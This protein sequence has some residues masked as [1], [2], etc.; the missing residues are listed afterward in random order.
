MTDPPK[1][2]ILTGLDI[3]NL[4]KARP[5]RIPSARSTSKIHKYKQKIRWRRLAIDAAIL[6]V[7]ISITYAY[8]CLGGFVFND[9]YI[10]KLITIRAA[11][12]SFWSNLVMKAISQPL[13]QPWI[14]AGFAF[15]LQNF[16]L[17]TVWYHIVN[18][19]LHFLSCFYFYILSYRLAK[20]FWSTGADEAP[21]HAVPLLAAALFACHPLACESVAHITG[22]PATVTACNFLLALNFFLSGFW[23]TKTFS[24]LRNYVFSFIF[25]ILA[26]FSDCQ[27]LAIPAVMLL[28]ALLL[29]DT[30][31]SYTNWLKIKWADFVFVAFF[32]I[33]AALSPV[34]GFTADL[35]NGFALPLPTRLVYIASQFRALITYYWRCFFVPLGLSVY[36]PFVTANGALD[37]F[38]ILG[39]IVI[40]AGFYYIYKWRKEPLAAFGLSLGVISFLPAI[41]FIQNE[42]AADRRFYL[43]IAG[44]SL[45]FAAKLKFWLTPQQKDHRIRLCALLVIIAFSGITAARTWDFQSDIDLLLAARRVNEKDAWAAGMLALSLVNTHK[46]KEGIINAKE[47]IKMNQTCQPAY[48]ALG[49][50]QMPIKSEE[51]GAI[52]KYKLAKDDFE[53]ALSLARSQHL[54]T[55]QLFDSQVSLASALIELNEYTQAKALAAESLLVAPN[56]IRLDLIMGRSLNGLGQYPEAL[57]YLD[58]AYSRDSTN[59]DLIEPL[60][61]ANLGVGAAS[62]ISTAYNIAKMGLK[63]KPSPKL[64]LLLARAAFA[65]R[66][67]GESIRWTNTVLQEE[68]NNPQAMYLSS[69]QLPLMG[70]LEAAKKLR[71]RALKLEPHLKTKMPLLLVNKQNNTVMRVENL[72][73]LNNPPR[74][75]YPFRQKQK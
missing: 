44:L 6:A 57:Q 5:T 24:A 7:I 34:S 33:L 47:A 12:E 40:A 59:P 67:I 37:I 4:G 68:P 36:P 42:I 51:R 21:L 52:E 43:C 70:R 10:D 64:H 28:L 25:F 9:H 54:G 45:L 19:I 48:L 20:H 74:A 3:A 73:E 30:N 13:S 66:Q 62:T 61:E 26:V 58:K 31:L 11:D 69:F 39:L 8:S 50:A 38:S 22:R 53:K 41:F 60:I 2:H 49:K 29:K 63:V 32:A 18:I 14:I 1:K 16:G 56:S 55:L 15:D 75:N 65:M 71:A 23:A 17:E 35:S 46:I 27:G 72:P